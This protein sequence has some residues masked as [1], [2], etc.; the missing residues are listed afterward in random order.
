MNTACHGGNR[1]R[2]NGHEGLL[3]AAHAATRRIRLFASSDEGRIP[4]RRGSQDTSCSA[5]ST[6][7][8]RMPSPVAILTEKRLKGVRRPRGRSCSS[9]SSMQSARD[10]A[11]GRNNED[12]LH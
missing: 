10:R 3:Q 7:Q 11:A 9:S 5:V 6:A 12:T 8:Y 1:L 4:Q 2:S